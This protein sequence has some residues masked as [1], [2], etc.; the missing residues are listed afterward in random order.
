MCVVRC[1]ASLSPPHSLSVTHS[2]SS[3]SILPILVYVYA[4]LPRSL[5]VLL[6]LA[7]LVSDELYDTSYTYIHDVCVCVCV[8]VC[9]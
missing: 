6:S 5:S 8:C 2:L 1:Y 7:F 4:L 9:V 3:P